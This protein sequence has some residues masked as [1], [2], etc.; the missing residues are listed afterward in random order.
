[1]ID[2]S[3]WMDRTIGW[4]KDHR[5]KDLFFLQQKIQEIELQNRT[6]R[7]THGDSAML[8]SPKTCDST[9]K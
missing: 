5:R 1:V 9:Q 2:W 3:N 4:S 8:R 6:S 7:S